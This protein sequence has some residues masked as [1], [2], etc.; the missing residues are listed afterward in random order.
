MT[1]LMIIVLVVFLLLA[2]L[3]LNLAEHVFSTSGTLTSGSFPGTGRFAA[4][5]HDK[6]PADAQAYKV[7]RS[8]SGT[9]AGMDALD[10]PNLPLLSSGGC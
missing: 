6:H 2:F 3:Y 7:D 4:R 10:A 9:D 8:E 5:E 1:P